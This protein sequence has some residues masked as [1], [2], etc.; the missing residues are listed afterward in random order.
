MDMVVKVEKELSIF[1]SVLVLPASKAVVSNFIHSRLN[2]IF[3]FT[4]NKYLCVIF[5][6]FLLIN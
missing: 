1:F 6:Y 5:I 4:I 3:T 2:F